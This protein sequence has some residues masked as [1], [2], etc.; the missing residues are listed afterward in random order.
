MKNTFDASKIVFSFAAISDI[1]MCND[2]TGRDKAFFTS[3]LTQIK[4]FGG[5]DAILAVGDLIN[6]GGY[7]GKFEQ[8]YVYKKVYESVLI[9]RKC[10]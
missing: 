9:R 4:E 5:V 2:N 7:G 8:I 1:H 6:A 10:P 3:A